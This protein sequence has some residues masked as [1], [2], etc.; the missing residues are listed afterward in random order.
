MKTLSNAW[1]FLIGAVLLLCRTSSAQ[2]EIFIKPGAINGKDAYVNTYYTSGN[3]TTPSFISSAWTYGGAEGIGRSF[4]QFELPVL[5]E[6]YS[7]FSATLNLYYDYSSQHVGHEGDNASKLERIT[8]EWS[9][10]TIDWYNQP[11]V[12]SLNSVFLPTSETSWQSYPNI[13]VTNLV[14]DMYTYPDES[15]GFRLSLLQE[16]IYRS[17]ILASSNHV[18]EEVRPSLIIRYDTCSSPVDSFSF[19]NEGQWC[20]FFHDDNTVNSWEWDFGNGYGSNLQNPE[21]YYNSPGTYQVCLLAINDC[22]E[23][24]IC[25]SVTVCISAEPDFVYSVDETTVSFTNLAYWAQTY[26]WDFGNGYFSFVENPVFHFDEPGVYEV[27]LTIEDGCQTASVCKTISVNI[28]LGTQS[29]QGSIENIYKSIKV[30]PIPTNGDLFVESK[31]MSFSR[32]ELLDSQSRVLREFNP[33]NS[34]DQ[35]PL[36][37]QQNQPGLYFLRITS[38]KGLIIKKIVVQR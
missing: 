9:D 1:L 4:I 11:E 36:S 35:F 17:M 30:F 37:L 3:S 22:G 7:N 33:T 8:E 16:Q 27:C 23:E 38:D 6:N 18:D 15:F 25:D 34:Q 21:Y 32:I 28:E 20:H 12:S 31:D 24:L 13:D 2:V 14:K 19:I 29:N 5:P 10:L 26:Y